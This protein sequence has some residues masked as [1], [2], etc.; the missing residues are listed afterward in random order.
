MPLN[1]KPQIKPQHIPKAPGQ[2]FQYQIQF[3]LIPRTF[4]G[5]DL[6]LLQR[7]DTVGEF[8]SKQR[9]GD[10]SVSLKCAYSA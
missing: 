9:G 2:E 6:N 1:K 3:I 5:G 10:K 8:S 7:G 4:A